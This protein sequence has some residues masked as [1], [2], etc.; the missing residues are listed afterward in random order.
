MAESQTAAQDSDP[1]AEIEQL[2]AE[3]KSLESKFRQMVIDVREAG[4]QYINSRTAD[5]A[6]GYVADYNDLV[7]EGNELLEEWMP[8]GLRIFELQIASQ[9]KPEPQFALFAGKALQ[10]K[11]DV[12]QYEPAFEIADRLF[13]LNASDRFAEI[14]R[15][16][17]GILSNRFGDDIS[18]SIEANLEFFKKK[19][20]ITD[21]ERMLISNLYAVRELYEVEAEIRK[22]EAQ[23]DDL[24]RVEFETSKGN[25]QIE[26]FENEAPESVAS[27]VYLVN[28]GHY[29]G[30][31]FHTVLDK[32]AA[33]TG[34]FDEEGK[35]R[36]IGYTTYD[37]NEK[38]NRRNIFAGSVVMNRNGPDSTRA[39]F[40]V[41]LAP[42]PNLNGQHTV[43]GTVIS[44]ME[45]VYK[46]NKTFE[47]DEGNQ[48][49]IEDVKPDRLIS[50]KVVRKRNHEYKP[51][52]VG[53]ANETRSSNDD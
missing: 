24:P 12:G 36:R 32:A 1:A 10:R 22:K 21:P 31:L 30:L 40:F 8:I 29:D 5:D 25:F 53:V 2:K 35:E 47:L 27:F 42:L 4:V 46:L 51:R 26:L 38:P 3:F 49:P 34:V 15:T 41:A 48:I 14:Y 43:V 11:F 37:E 50:A 19:E 44:G 52:K 45:S 17:S 20:N 39:R 33:E 18:D 23:A 7:D 16:R 9:G 13:K 28:S 6:Y